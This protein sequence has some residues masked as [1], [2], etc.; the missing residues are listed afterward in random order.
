MVGE[1]GTTDAVEPQRPESADPSLGK[2]VSAVVHRLIA[3]VIVVA[4]LVGAYF[5]LEAFLP[6]WWAQ[7]IGRSIGGAFSRGIGSGFVIGFVCTFI[8]IL[9]VVFAVI[10]RGRLKNVP[11]A[12]CGIGA[13]VVAIPNLLTLAVVAGRGNGSHAGQRIFDVDAPGFRGA[14]LGGAIA[15]ALTAAGAAYFIWG[16]RRRGRKLHEAKA[17]EA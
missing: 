4:A 10:S 5:L 15:G 17:R 2:R 13:I 12:V 3:A 9:L 8:P 7:Q 16:Y 6:R 1:Q 14:T 11:A